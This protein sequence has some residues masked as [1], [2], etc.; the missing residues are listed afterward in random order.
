MD[1][2]LLSGT[3]LYSSLKPPLRHWYSQSDWTIISVLTLARVPG[4]VWL[5]ANTYLYHFFPCLDCC[6]CDT[7]L[8]KQRKTDGWIDGW[9]QTKQQLL[10]RALAWLLHNKTDFM[11]EGGSTH[12]KPNLQQEKLLMRTVRLGSGHTYMTHQRTNKFG[13]I[14]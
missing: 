12:M 11:L 13:P 1:K 3:V 4:H 10:V 14:S 9:T 7:T 6:P 5:S 8:D 2:R